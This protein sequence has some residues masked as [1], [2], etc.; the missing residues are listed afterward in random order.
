MEELCERCQ[1]L[2]PYVAPHGRH[3][4][5]HQRCGKIRPVLAK[6]LRLGSQDLLESDATRIRC[7]RGRLPAPTLN[8][9]G[10]GRRRCGRVYAQRDEGRIG[11]AASR[12]N[13][14]KKLVRQGDH[15]QKLISGNHRRGRGSRGCRE[16]VASS[17]HGLERDRQSISQQLFRYV[18]G[19]LTACRDET[20]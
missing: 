9:C 10:C 1:T 8:H 17:E 6:K 2:Q 5:L 4:H 3:D 7:F 15:L 11:C 18:R 14:R 20:N 16:H 12:L 13:R 19:T